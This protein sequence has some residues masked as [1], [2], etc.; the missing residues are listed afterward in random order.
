MW[1]NLPIYSQKRPYVV[2]TFANYNSFSIFFSHLQTSTLSKAIKCLGNV[3]SV[4]HGDFFFHCMCRVHVILKFQPRTC[5]YLHKI[6]RYPDTSR[7]E[8]CVSKMVKYTSMPS[9]FSF[10]YFLF[11]WFFFF[12]SRANDILTL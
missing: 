2:S 1:I 9:A 6:H 12:L 11:C 8:N 4:T 5:W 10:V 7:I 3:A